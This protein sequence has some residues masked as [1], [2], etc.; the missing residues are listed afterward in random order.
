MPKISKKPTTAGRK[1]QQG[2]NTQAALPN[3]LPSVS[4]VC[5]CFS[6]DQVAQ[7]TQIASQTILSFFAN[8][9][10]IQTGRIDEPSNKLQEPSTLFN[11]PFT[12]NN[13]VD[14]PSKY[15]HNSGECFKLGLSL[16]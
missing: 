12:S 16:T 11:Q 1:A 2:F 3:N 9:Q 14:I 4:T 6:N 8:Q 5:E 13:E 7:I 10:A 15:A